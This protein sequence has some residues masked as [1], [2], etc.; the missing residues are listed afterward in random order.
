MN[1]EGIGLILRRERNPDTM[2]WRKKEASGKPRRPSEQASDSTARDTRDDR[3]GTI[4]VGPYQ[5]ETGLD[6]LCL[7][8]PARLVALRLIAVEGHNHLSHRTV[9]ILLK[10]AV[11]LSA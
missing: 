4:L 7:A 3:R 8:F 6:I 10:H 9:A 11:Q 1:E 2:E 5:P